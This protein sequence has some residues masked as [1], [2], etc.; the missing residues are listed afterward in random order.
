MN[1]ETYTLK[2]RFGPIEVSKDAIE[3]DFTTIPVIDLTDMTSPD[4]EKRKKLASQIYDASSKVGFFYIKVGRANTSESDMIIR[5]TD[6]RI[7]VLPKRASKRS[8]MPLTST[9]LS[10]SRRRWR[11]TWVNRWY[12]DSY[13]SPLLN[14]Y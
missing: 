14:I 1:K 2:T 5:L 10:L 4:L 11:P 6:A 13:P 9:L 7:T 12:V 3:G 8:M